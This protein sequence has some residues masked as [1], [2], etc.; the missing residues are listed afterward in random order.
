MG[1]P[2]GFLVASFR[3]T[4]VLP[5]GLGEECVSFLSWCVWRR[6]SAPSIFNFFRVSRAIVLKGGQSSYRISDLSDL[7]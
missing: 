6:V 4:T 1:F 2:F 3:D 7:D 5:S